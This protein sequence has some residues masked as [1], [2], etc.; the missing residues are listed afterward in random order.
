MVLMDCQ[1]YRMNHLGR[2]HPLKPAVHELVKSVPCAGPDALLLVREHGPYRRI[3]QAF[4][5]TKPLKDASSPIISSI[6]VQANCI[7]ADP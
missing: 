4:T 7:E 6:S 1:N 2:T 5:G 3:Q